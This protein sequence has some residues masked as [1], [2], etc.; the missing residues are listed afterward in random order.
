MKTVSLYFTIFI[1]FMG[2]VSDAATTIKKAEDKPIGQKFD[3][4]K[5]KSNI[6]E[7]GV[8]GMVCAFCAQGIEKKFMQQKEVQAILVSL[9]NKKITITF[10]PGQRL[11]NIKISSLL[12]ESG[13]EPNF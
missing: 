6:L 13:Y 12:K 4:S 10:K 7:V 11:T 3:S 9:E 8:K 5:E 2:F 1:G